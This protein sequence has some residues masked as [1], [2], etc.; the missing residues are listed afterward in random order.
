[1]AA[2]AEK[3][4]LD[5]LLARVRAAKASGGRTGNSCKVSPYMHVH[6]HVQLLCT[7]VLVYMLLLK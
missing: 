4:Q 2:R 3:A 6:G 7:L 1:M 5:D